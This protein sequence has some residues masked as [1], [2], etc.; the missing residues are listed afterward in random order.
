VNKRWL[1]IQTYWYY[2]HKE[3]SITDDKIDVTR[4]GRRRPRRRLMG[5]N[6]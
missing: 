5:T 2:T 3:Q 1:A 6:Y 4:R